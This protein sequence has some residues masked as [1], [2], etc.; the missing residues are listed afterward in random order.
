MMDAA[1][2]KVAEPR[3]FDSVL[4]ANRGEIAL[5]V[6]RAC[7]ELGLKTVMIHSE[8]DKD[9]DYLKAADTAIC[10]G[11]A[12]PG[13]S[14]LNAPAILLAMELTGAGAVHPG[15]GFRP[16]EHLFGSRGGCRGGLHRP[17]RRRHPHHG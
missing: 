8:A 14:Y 17:A 7:R 6:Q 4:I 10:I 11:P 16:K 3:A 13:Q 15:Y 12:S 1:L 5:R 9:A 2:P